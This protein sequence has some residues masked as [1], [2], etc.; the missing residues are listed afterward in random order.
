MNKCV[1]LNHA[2]SGFCLEC[3]NSSNEKMKPKSVRAWAVTSEFG[4]Y[5]LA[6]INDLPRLFATKERA[7][8]WKR[9]F[10]VRVVEVEIRLIKRKKP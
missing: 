1:G 9:M 5:D 2:K 7:E 6:E 8:N 10:N 4:D 3:F